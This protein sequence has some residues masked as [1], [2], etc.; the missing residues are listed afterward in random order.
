MTKP[1]W[2]SEALW[3]TCRTAFQVFIGVV[4]MVVIAVLQDY[5]TTRVFDWT[6]LWYQ[7]IVAGIAAAVAYLMNRK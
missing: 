5:A 7:G 1:D 6:M 3:R 4:G 2:M